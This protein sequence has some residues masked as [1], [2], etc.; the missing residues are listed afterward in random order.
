MVFKFFKEIIG[1]VKEG[2]D[3]AKQEVAQE[4][5]EEQ[6]KEQFEHEKQF[7]H[8]KALPQ[9]EV[10][11]TALGAPYRRLFVA[12]IPYYLSAMDL[13]ADKK[14]ELAQLIARDFDVTDKTSLMRMAKTTQTHLYAAI[15]LQNTDVK[16]MS[17]EELLAFNSLLPF[18]SELD[19]ESITEKHLSFARQL[20]LEK[21]ASLKFN[22]PE[23]S[24]SLVALWMSRF[25]YAASVSV[26]LGYLSIQEAYSLFEPIVEVGLTQIS[27]WQ[28]FG[29]LFVKGEKQD[30]TNNV[31]GRKV[32][33][34]QVDQLF[35]QPLSPWLVQVW[36]QKL[37]DL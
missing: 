37:T 23:D 9:K 6:E 13:P 32:L 25:S 11:F 30:G 10:F 2:I 14:E 29:A 33:S 5:A 27:D 34:M 19:A 8:I 16:V 4:Q 20:F 3:E 36:P 7:K 22:L 28:A 24:K 18:L 17:D 35:K 15:F 12:D 1:A 26:G 21:F 31:L